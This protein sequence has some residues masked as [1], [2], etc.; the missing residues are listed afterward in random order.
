MTFKKGFSSTISFLGSTGEV[1]SS[2]ASTI[3]T[4]STTSGVSSAS[5]LSGLSAASGTIV[6]RSDQ[7]RQ[8]ISQLVGMGYTEVNRM[9]KIQQ[10]VII[11]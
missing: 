6:E 7:Q 4:I 8:A 3:S 5:G 11:I 9:K 10:K 1:G 2:A